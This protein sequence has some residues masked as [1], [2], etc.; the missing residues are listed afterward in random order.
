ML[1]F[2][3]TFLPSCLASAAAQT[4][5]LDVVVI[6]T[7]DQAYHTIEF[8]PYTKAL[9]RDQGVEFTN[10]SAETPWCCPS[11]AS[12]FTGLYTRNHGVRALF[13]PRGGATVFEDGST[14]ATWLDAAG[15][16]TGLF[17]KYLN[18]YDK[19][20]PYVPPGWDEWHAF[21]AAAQYSFYNYSLVSNGTVVSYGKTS[22]EYSTYVLRDKALEFIRSTPLGTPLFLYFSPVAPH[23]PATPAPEDLGTFATQ[24]GWRSPNYNET[25]V[26]DKPYWVRQLALL[27]VEQAAKVDAVYRRQ[28]ES[29]QAVDRA[30][31]QIV[32]VLGETGRLARTA[33]VFTSDHGSALGA[34]RYGYKTCVYE[35]CV[36]VPFIVRAPGVLA[37]TDPSLV[38]NIDIAPTIADWAGL[39]P[40]I[41][42]DGRTLVALLANPSAPWRDAALVELPVAP[43]PAHPFNAV[44]TR[45]YTYAEYPNG[46]RE[47]YDRATDP[48]QLTNVVRKSAYAGVVAALRAKLQALKQE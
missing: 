45:R 28:L 21:V 16:R 31:A 5:P 48:W 14:V 3:C 36:R 40:P 6:V 44:R 24:P 47:L 22:S 42:V 11:R 15:Y 30:V 39:T 19:L 29:L 4:L 13:A 27:S 20:V 10:A 32:A 41:R 46:D 2:L 9:I 37:R 25:Y 33:I 8:M 43:L 23:E 18:D 34:H 7:D 38:Q 17:G 1:A 12:I 26:G 35:E